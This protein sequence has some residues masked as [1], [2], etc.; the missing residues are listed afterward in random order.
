MLCCLL[1]QSRCAQRQ[2]FCGCSH[3]HVVCCGLLMWQWFT[4]CCE[5]SDVERRLGCNAQSALSCR[6][7]KSKAASAPRTALRWATTTVVKRGVLLTLSTCQLFRSFIVGTV[8]CPL[9]LSLS[10]SLSGFG[11]ERDYVSDYGRDESDAYVRGSGMTGH[12]ELRL[13]VDALLF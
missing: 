13:F 1:P 6:S 5:P 2:P 10:L 7:Q 12:Q 11:T 8:I 9:S 3:T 4:K